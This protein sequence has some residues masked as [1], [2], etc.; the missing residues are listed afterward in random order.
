M[1]A[2]KLTHRALCVYGELKR[3][4]TASGDKTREFVSEITAALLQLPTEEQLTIQS[5][6]IMQL[7]NEE[8]A[9]AMDCD[10][11]T[12]SRRKRRALD[13]LALYMYTDK[14]LQDNGLQG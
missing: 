7:T 6:Y 2:Y 13:R 12:V 4:K 5:I 14:Y 1:D 8:T 11:S 3:A 10:P 9:E